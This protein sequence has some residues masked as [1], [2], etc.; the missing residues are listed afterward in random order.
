MTHDIFFAICQNEVDGV[1]PSESTMWRNFFD[2]VELADRLGFGCAWVA[3]T[4]LSSEVQKRNPGAVIPSFKGEIGLNTDILQLAHK[5]FARTKRINVGS[6]IRNILCNGGPMAHAEAVRTFLS[7]HGLDPQET[8]V[9]EFGFA[10]GRFPYSVVPYGVRPRNSFEAQAWPVLKGL[11]FQEAAEI[12]LRFLRGDIFSSSDVRS[13]ILRPQH[14]RSNEDW[15]KAVAAY[16]AHHASEVDSSMVIDAI[17]V[18]PFWVFD[19]VGVIPKEAP[20][21]LLRLT[22]GAHD[23]AT[24]ELVN[25]FM[26]V[27]VFNLSITADKVINDTQSR[28]TKAFHPAGGAWTRALMPRTLMVFPDH[29]ERKARTQA[30]KTLTTFWQAMEGTVDP[31]KVAH[32]VENA[33]VGT[34]AMIV[35]QLRSRVH[36]DDRLMLWFDLNNHDNDAVMR[37]MRMY[38]EEVAPHV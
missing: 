37:A 11:V 8:R 15:Q 20:L 5:V 13:K 21:N 17:E 36:R 24:Q 4:H 6:A 3:E 7:L 14:F 9:L 33:L 22:V 34:P 19:Q 30:E 12:F 25:Q 2:Q 29:D 27:G 16:G 23:S 18:P 1:T 28:M 31:S 10:S 35:D 38:M 26:P 32:A